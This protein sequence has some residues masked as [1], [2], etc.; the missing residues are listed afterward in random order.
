ME[1]Q[2]F[3]PSA[4]AYKRVTGPY[5]ENY[6]LPCEQ[7]YQWSEEKGVADSQ[8]IFV[9]RDDPQVTSPQ[10]C[11]TDIC[12]LVPDDTEITGIVSK[13]HFDG[14]RYAFIRKVI[15]DKSEYPLMW[16]QLLREAGKQFEWDDDRTCVCFE[17][18]HSYDMETHI[19]DVSFCIAVK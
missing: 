15:N 16:Q 3:K 19:A 1:T 11:R 9:Y 14:G 2:L 10:D 6:E 8:W 17:L 13:A 18:Y 4:L 12:L 7:L 5:G